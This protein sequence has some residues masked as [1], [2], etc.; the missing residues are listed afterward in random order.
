M[1]RSPRL[2]EIF[3]YSPKKASDVSVSDSRM[4][5]TRS[6]SGHGGG[7]GGG[8]GDGGAGGDGGI[9]GGA[10]TKE[11]D[12]PHVSS[13]PVMHSMIC[14][15]RAW[16]YQFAQP[17]RTPAGSSAQGCALLVRPTS[18]D[19]QLGGGGGGGGNGGGGEGDGGGGGE[20]GATQGTRVHTCHQAA[21]GWVRGLRAGWRLQLLVSAD[22]GFVSRSV[23]GYSLY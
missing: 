16:W 1:G 15:L 19:S 8:G 9:G 21:E 6:A 22:L 18:R 3:W 4:P 2:A 20:G 14:P 12:A 17:P 7:A 13:P 10:H 23:T 5:L 11:I